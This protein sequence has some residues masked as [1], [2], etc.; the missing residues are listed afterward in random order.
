MSRHLATLSVYAAHPNTGAVPFATLILNKEGNY[1]GKNCSPPDLLDPSREVI[2]YA[3][4]FKEKGDGFSYT[5]ADCTGLHTNLTHKLERRQFQLNWSQK[6]KAFI[7]SVTG[8][9]GVNMAGQTL[10]RAYST[11]PLLENALFAIPAQDPVFYFQINYTS[12]ESNA[13]P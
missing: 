9:S 4:L 1:F 12:P 2:N 10:D 11:Q 8:Q 6:E 7:L 5:I 13:S 3:T